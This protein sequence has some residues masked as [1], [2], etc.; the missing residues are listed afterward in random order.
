[1]SPNGMTLSWNASKS[2]ELDQRIQIQY[3]HVRPREG[4]AISKLLC[5]LDEEG[6]LLPAELVCTDQS[7]KVTDGALKDAA[8]TSAQDTV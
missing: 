8:T 2:L 3:T 6:V 1:M 4:Q 5:F 7:S